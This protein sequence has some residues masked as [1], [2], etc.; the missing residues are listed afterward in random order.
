MVKI[1]VSEEEGYRRYHGV[2]R[3]RSNDVNGKRQRGSPVPLSTIPSAFVLRN[4]K[5]HTKAFA[6][7]ASSGRFVVA[8]GASLDSQLENTWV[9]CVRL[10]HSRGKSLRRLK[11]KWNNYLGTKRL[12]RL[13]S[14]TRIL[15]SFR[16]DREIRQ[17]PSERSFMKTQESGNDFEGSIENRKR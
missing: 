3:A 11:M 2:K 16:L 7:I 6:L 10:R 4:H 12:F 8:V 14:R 1:S 17:A 5:V 13:T 15:Y 9:K